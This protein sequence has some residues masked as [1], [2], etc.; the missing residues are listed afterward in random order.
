MFTTRI[1]D[2]GEAQR[3]GLVNYVVAPEKL[4]E[5]SFD[6]AMEMTKYPPAALGMTKRI[7]N[8]SMNLDLNGLL[9][10]EGQAQG[11]LFQ[12][13]NFQEGRK[14]FLEKREAKFNFK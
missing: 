10:L 8:Q 4:M 1:I 7:I 14:A 12:T 5:R 11:I 3:I 9:E 2:A 13:E 6:L